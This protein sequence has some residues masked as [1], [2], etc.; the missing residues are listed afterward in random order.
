MIG[1]PFA[2]GE[3]VKGLVV[4]FEVLVEQIPVGRGLHVLCL[5]Q[6]QSGVQRLGIGQGVREEVEQ[7]PPSPQPLP[8][9]AARLANGSIGRNSA[10]PAASAGE[11]PTP[12]RNSILE[13]LR[14]QRNSVVTKPPAR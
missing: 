7:R 1:Q 8:G 4:L 6:Q 9:V 12:P 5:F 2:E 11:A 14:A 3:E 10:P 13:R